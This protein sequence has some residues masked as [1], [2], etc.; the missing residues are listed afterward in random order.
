ME[1]VNVHDPKYREAKTS[2][3]SASTP[4]ANLFRLDDRTIVG[5]SLRL[6]DSAENDVI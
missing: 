1:S 2:Q 3:G 4:V 6:I 5:A